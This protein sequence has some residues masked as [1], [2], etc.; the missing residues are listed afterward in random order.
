MKVIL[1][2]FLISSSF[3]VQA[4][5][6]R[7]NLMAGRANYSGEI[8]P[9]SFTFNQSNGAYG[10]G[11]SIDLS[12]KIVLRGEYLFTRLGADDKLSSRPDYRMRNL[13][14]KTFIR[15]VNLVGEF[16]LR[17]SYEHKFVPYVFGGVGL[18]RFSPYTTDSVY[19]KQY[20]VG[21]NTEGQG[22]PEFPDRQP[23][24]TTQLNLPFGGGVK[25]FLSEDVNFSVEFGIRVLFTD[26]LDDVSTTYVD[27]TT[28]LNARGPV[29]V[30]L[31]FRGDEIKSNPQ[32]Y[33]RGGTQRGSPKAKDYYYYG[34]A[35]IGIRINSFD[36][37]KVQ[38]GRR[39]KLD[40][41]SRVL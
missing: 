28:L 25:Y 41:P 4:Q 6:L 20:L 31:A 9:R 40:C 16:N 5:N 34:L 7:L 39:G 27:E 36:N 10:A 13:N 23:Y 24:K 26:Y 30:A 17:N 3:I 2:I 33:P 35:K 19:G 8:Q 15:E 11:A 1:L 22:L 32:Q 21:L 37:G 18:F 14:F 29:A 38:S 12:D